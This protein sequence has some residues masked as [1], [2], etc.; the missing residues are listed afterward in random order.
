MVERGGDDREKERERWMPR[1]H[2]FHAIWELSQSADCVTQSENPQIACQ[3]ADCVP[4]CRLSAQSANCVRSPRNLEIA[5][6]FR[7][8]A[9]AASHARAV[10]SSDVSTFATMSTS[11]EEQS[12]KLLEEFW[13]WK[14]MYAAARISQREAGSESTERCDAGSG[15]QV[16]CSSRIVRLRQT[17]QNHKAIIAKNFSLVQA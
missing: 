14:Y 17:T 13:T 6:E 15:A 9:C 8:H 2:L 5:H 10:S 11:A 3:S 12:R 1:C 16:R 7:L 4:I